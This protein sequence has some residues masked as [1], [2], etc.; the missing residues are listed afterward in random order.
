MLNYGIS[1]SQSEFIVRIDPDDRFS[2]KKIDYQIKMK[3][4]LADISY[5][6]IYINNKKIIKYPKTKKIFS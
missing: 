1:K 3:D 4:S 2:M 6:N 5:T